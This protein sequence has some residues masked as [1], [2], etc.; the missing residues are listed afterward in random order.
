MTQY[1]SKLT[2]YDTGARCE[3]KLWQSDSEAAAEAM[4]SGDAEDIG[5]VDFTDEADRTVATVHIS[6]ADS[7]M[8]TVHLMPACGDDQI[9][10]ELHAKKG[11]VAIEADTGRQA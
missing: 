7:G 5:K 3:P 10:V 1:Q 4:R 6:C 9:R 11:T 8:F 2:P